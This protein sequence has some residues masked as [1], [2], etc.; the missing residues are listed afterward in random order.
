L[1]KSVNHEGE[2][3]DEFETTKIRNVISKETSDRIRKIMLGV[4]E[5][6]TGS[7]AQQ[8]NVYVGGKTGTTQKLI[9]GKYSSRFY[10]SSFI[11]FFPAEAPK[12]IC[13]VLIDS[14][15]KGRYGGQVAAPI[16]GNITK[17]ILET[18]FSIERNKEE[19]ERANL[20]HEF[21]ANIE[22]QNKEENLIS[23]ANVS[24][25]SNVRVSKEKTSRSTMPNLKNKSLRSAIKILSDLNI[26]YTIN[27]RGK[28]IDQSIKIGTAIKN[29]MNCVLTCSTEKVGHE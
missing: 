13:F 6:G 17:K 9:D 3:E 19:I 8:S 1:K 15:K 11:G 23:F 21:T 29:G 22:K 25:K 16:F 18:D 7:K 20:I 2:I 24:E 28:I 10:N 12:I 4:V 14:P 26:T 27:G 5:N